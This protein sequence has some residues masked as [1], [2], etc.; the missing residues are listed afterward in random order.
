MTESWDAIVVG[1]GA[2]GLFAALRAKELSPHLRLLVAEASAK[3]LRKV[4]ISGGGRCNV[5]HACDD[6]DWLL[7]CY[8]RGGPRLEAILS[9]FMP[10]DTVRWFLEHGVK[11]KA[12]PDGRMFPVTNSSQTI[13]DCFQRAGQQLGI[14]LR[15]EA[16]IQSL[17]WQ[18]SGFFELR[19]GSQKL[20]ATKVLLSTGGA[21]KATRWL[22]ELGHEIVSDVPSLF[23]FCVK[24]PVI[25]GLQGI[26][27]APVRLRLK[28]DE[29]N[30]EAE[31]PML[32]THWGLSGPAVL[33]LSAFSARALGQ[34][35][36]EGELCCDLIPDLTWD[37]VQQTLS[38]KGEQHVST[39]SP[40]ASVPKRLWQRLVQ[41]ARIGEST[42]WRRL[43][44]VER[45]ALAQGLKRLRLKVKGKG[46][47]KEEFVTS[48]GLP[49]RE[50]DPYTMESRKTPGLFIAGE[51]L[52]VDGITG[53]FNF[54]HAWASGYIAG[55]SLARSKE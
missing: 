11:L 8:P 41:H 36:Y 23:T 4:A 1:A 19:C 6:L 37:I 51:L 20:R 48:G 40:F 34:S 30:F 35:Q 7:S 31:G 28:V 13:I 44:S 27:I 50:I 3:P 2:A 42:P 33:K 16:K 10:E 22:R 32:I 53:G 24:H 43:P 14:T 38:E 5:T 52:D 49:L 29:E 46:P 55:E 25:D 12:E 26:S 47:F 54:Q 39:S 21:S 9:R 15:T 45:E 17:R 18:D